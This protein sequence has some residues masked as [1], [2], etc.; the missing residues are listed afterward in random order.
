MTTASSDLAA[1]AALVS[2]EAAFTPPVWVRR[3]SPGERAL[4]C[5]HDP[6]GLGAGV[7]Y[8]PV[9]LAGDAQ[10]GELVHV[11]RPDLVFYLAS[12]VQGLPDQVR[13]AD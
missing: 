2:C 11:A 5:Q 3:C 10:A 13:A 8:D 12:L 9:D 7:E 4:A 6:S 1:R